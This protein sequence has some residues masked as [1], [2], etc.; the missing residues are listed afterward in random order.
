MRM[1][2]LGARD[3]G[4]LPILTCLRQWSAQ[5]MK[6]ENLNSS[7]TAAVS[8]NGQRMESNCESIPDALDRTGGV[9][10]GEYARLHMPPT[11]GTLMYWSLLDL[12][13]WLTAPLAILTGAMLVR[14]FI[15]FHDCGHGSFFRSKMR[16][17]DVV[18]FVTGVVTL[19]P[20]Y[21]WRWGALASSRNGG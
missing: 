8:P 13:A 17:N 9:A 16:P 3:N 15:I 2:S 12:S 14:V 20:Y 10:T 6:T 11:L 5:R 7:G 1:K 19:T 18:G 21:H 4:V